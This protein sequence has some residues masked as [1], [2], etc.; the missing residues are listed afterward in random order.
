MKRA[1]LLVGILGLLGVGGCLSPCLPPIASFTACPE[2]S[3]NHLDL[4]FSS[5]SQTSDGHALVFFRWDFGDGTTL[6]DYYGW[7]T[8]RYAEPATYTVSLTV[9][10]DRGVKATT[11]QHVVVGPVVELRDVT[12]SSGYPSRAEGTLANVSSYFLYSASIKVKF[13]DAEGVRVAETTVDVLSID[14]GERVRFIAEAPS[15]VG[16]VV[17]ASAFI[18]SF[19][20]ECSGGVFPIPVDT[21]G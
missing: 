15:D 2:G 8:H 21:D 11:E 10:D 9:T 18:Q 16:S 7:A 19:A 17:S 14:P 1:I 12:F 20:A 6:D 13:Y 4:Q 3:S 5:T